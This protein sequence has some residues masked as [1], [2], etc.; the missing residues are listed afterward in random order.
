MALALA[1]EPR[2]QVHVIL[3]ERSAGFFALG[4]GRATGLP[5]IVLCT[6]GTAAA[7]LHPAVLEASYGRVPLLVCTAD[8]PAELRGIGAGQTVDQAHLYG[9]APRLFVD[10]A[11]PEDRS[12]V[13]P[14]WRSLAAR[15]FAT[16]VGMPPGPVHLNLAFREPLVPT[17]APLVEAPGRPGDRPWTVVDRARPGA[18]A[19]AVDSLAARVATA[20]KGLLVAGWGAEAGADIVR[21]FVEASGW[22]LLADP[23]SGLRTDPSAITTYDTLLRIPDPAGVRTPELVLRLGAMPTSKV[24]GARL[25]PPLPVIRVDPTGSWLDP[26]RADEQ[27]IVADADALLGAVTAR[28]AARG[29]S[30]WRDGWANAEQVARRTIDGFLEEQEAPF[31][32]R[33]ARDVLAVLPDGS[34]LFVASSMP[35]RDLDTFGAARHAV[36]VLANRGVNGIDGLVS[37]ALGIAAASGP[38]PT[39]ALLGDLAFLHDTGGLLGAAARGI[40]IVFVVVDNDGGGIFSFLPQAE[41]PEHFE[42]LFATPH[43]VDLGAIAAAH[44]IPVR[45]VTRSKDLGPAVRAALGERGAQMVHV[46]TDR[47]TNVELHRAAT[48][49]V[50]RAITSAPGG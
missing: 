3:D 9:T 37:S 15:A 45:R 34:D 22:P 30:P 6:S 4:A 10:V 11:A 21:D 32:G 39:V 16:T 44:S 46:R 5:A 29:A 31:E 19:H 12:G 49:A 43:G 38:R 42:R 2:L 35:V 7:G 13:G 8:R 47:T 41:L 28:L 23:L 14:E 20:P 40:D 50:E 18:E 17:G 24:L 25:A 27:L 36:R 26:N 48:G 33:I 1:D